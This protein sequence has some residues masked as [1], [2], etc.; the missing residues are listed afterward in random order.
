VRTLPLPATD[1]QE[2]STDRSTLGFASRIRVQ[3]ASVG[4][5]ASRS[6]Y[7]MV[8]P[9]TSVLNAGVGL[10]LPLLFGPASFG[11]YALAATLFQYGIIFD[12]GASQL[13]DRHVPALVGT[14]QF[15]QA[16]RIV[17]ELLWLRLSIALIVITL[18]GGAVMMAGAVWQTSQASAPWAL[19]L[20]AG[21]LFMIGN[22]PSSVYRARS[23]AREYALSN[24]LLNG[25]LVLARP[26]GAALA[27]LNGCFGGMTLWYLVSTAWL[28]SRI[29]LRRAARPS[30]VRMGQLVVA[31]LPL[32]A[33]S[34]TWAF[35]TSAN[36]WFASLVTTPLELGHFAFG[37]NIL[38]LVIGTIGGLTAFYYPAVARKIA[39]SPGFACSG[40]LTRDHVVLILAMAVTS[41]IG[42]LMVPTFIRTLYHDYQTAILPTQI[43]LVST[44]PMVLAAW[45]MPLSLSSGRHPWIGCVGVYPTAVAALGAAIFLLHG[46]FGLSGIAAASTVSGI[47]L[48]T[49]QLILL[50]REAILR[51]RDCCKIWCV[52]VAA[53]G[54]IS[55]VFAVLI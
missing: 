15:E 22:G 17:N 46:R 50:W 47:V 27:G 21:V 38:Y 18:A 34:L 29:P 25:G 40:L 23:Q 4:K 19:S 16:E 13:F 6:R 31:G 12:L 2:S 49:L 48:I 7:A 39:A 32:F 30:A 41:V 26:I 33:A 3:I 35:L 54:V 24:L 28:Q 45:L 14:G 43:L 37:A 8:V 5:A 1:P 36:R 55:G 9:L 51:L 42:M 53:T 10:I 20:T 44:T 52:A 11:Q